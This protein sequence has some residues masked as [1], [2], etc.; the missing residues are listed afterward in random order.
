LAGYGR[1]IGCSEWPLKA[2]GQTRF[3]FNA[4]A[5]H[6][7]IESP[8]PHAAGRWSQRRRDRRWCEPLSARGDRRAADNRYVALPYRNI[9]YPAM[10]AWELREVQQKLKAQGMR[11]VDEHMIFEAL[12]RM[13]V[14][15]EEAKLKTKAARR[16]ATRIPVAPV[17]KAVSKPQPLQEQSLTDENPAASTVDEDP[18]SQP[19]R[20]FDEISISR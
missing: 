17:S 10:S 15:V 11:N 2:Q 6:A 9:G 1:S 4:R 18:F 7:G 19:I 12:D 5:T 20:P 3:I 8:L 13:R 14:R 16:Q